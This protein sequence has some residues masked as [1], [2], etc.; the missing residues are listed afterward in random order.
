VVRK[1]NNLRPAFVERIMNDVI[2]VW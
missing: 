2:Y 1:H